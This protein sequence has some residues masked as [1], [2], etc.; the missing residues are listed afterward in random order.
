MRKK[1]KNHIAKKLPVFYLALGP[2]PKS[3][4]SQK[5]LKASKWRA[6]TG[7]DTEVHSEQGEPGM[8]GFVQPGEEKTMGRGIWFLSFYCLMEG[9]W[10]NED[11]PFWKMHSERTRWNNHNLCWRPAGQNK[12]CFTFRGV[13]CWNKIPERVEISRSPAL[14]ISK[15][16]WIR[17]QEI[18]STFGV[19]PSL[20]MML[21]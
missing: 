7:G 14:E 6:D 10:R 16:C 3:Q 9:K 13:Q 19:R 2:P 11:S 1:I 12:N 17:P 15:P 18:W 4:K 8:S 20:T 5:N 21:D